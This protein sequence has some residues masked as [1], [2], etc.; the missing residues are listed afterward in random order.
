MAGGRV[1]RF[2]VVVGRVVE[3]HVDD[4]AG[5]CGGVDAVE[6][7]GFVGGRAVGVVE[8]DE[9]GGVAVCGTLGLVQGEGVA[10]RVVCG[11]LL[12]DV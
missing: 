7:E 3:A 1:D 12:L 6:G 8:G 9:D 10:L 2:A 4:L 11:V 5:F